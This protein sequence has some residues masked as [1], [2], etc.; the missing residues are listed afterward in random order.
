MISDTE[1]LIEKKTPE[2]TNRHN[3]D[4][5]IYAAEIPTVGRMD[6]KHTKI[7]IIIR[8]VLYYQHLSS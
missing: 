8:T 5:F 4:M 7:S 3:L 1:L 2:K 6:K